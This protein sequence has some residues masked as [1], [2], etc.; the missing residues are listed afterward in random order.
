MEGFMW[1]TMLLALTAQAA[2]PRMS[3]REVVEWMEAH[4]KHKFVYSADL[5]LQHTQVRCKK[6][7]L[8]PAKAYEA[9]LA[10]LK[11]VRL[12]AVRK[13]KAG[14]VEISPAPLGGKAE[15]PVY[16]SVQ[17]LPDADEFCSLV[18]RP[19]FMD[20]RSAQAV[21]INMAGFPQNVLSVEDPPGLILSDYASNLRRLAALL[22]EIDRPKQPINPRIAARLD[23]DWLV[24]KYL[25][26]RF[27]PLPA[28]QASNVPALLEAL[29]ADSVA[30]REGAARDLE[31]MGPNVS[32]LLASALDA[33]DVEVRARVQALLYKWAEA[34]ARK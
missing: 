24:R 1:V 23:V 9:G 30:G 3:A 19:R 18:L 33:K 12:I 14:V 13:E 31:A 10:L 34:W 15:V 6:E 29:G 27:D 8:D 2:E 26:R 7:D 4:T 11:T 5:G 32:P 22:A 20:A 16:T 25:D 17:Q 21:L 28:D